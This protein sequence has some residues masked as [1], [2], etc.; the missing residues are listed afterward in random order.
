VVSGLSG[1]SVWELPTGKLLRK[2]T[3]GDSGDA[4]FCK[5]GSQLAYSHAYRDMES[6]TFKGKVTIVDMGTGN[7][8][9]ELSGLFSSID[10]IDYDSITDVFA[11]LC[12]DPKSTKIRKQEIVLWDGKSKKRL[13]TKPGFYDYVGFLAGQSVFFSIESD[14]DEHVAGR[15]AR[16][17]LSF[18]EVPSGRESLRVALRPVSRLAQSHDRRLVA[19]ASADEDT[20]V[21]VIDIIDVKEINVLR[22][23]QK[24]RAILAFGLSDRVLAVAGPDGNIRFWDFRLEMEIGQLSNE[25]VFTDQNPVMSMVFSPDSE[26]LVIG[27]LD[28]TICIWQVKDYLEERTRKQGKRN[29]PGDPGND[30]KRNR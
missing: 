20:S 14:V 13:I 24:G 21:R 23:K 25:K 26:V 30:G 18:I 19:T 5:K 17:H 6:G 10:G 9:G 11:I 1:V 15:S 29:G 3:D 22:R 8:V 12:T 4:C 7:P 28:G 27:T 16:L 2:I